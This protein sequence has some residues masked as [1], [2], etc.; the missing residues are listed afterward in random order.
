MAALNRRNI[1]A[2]IGLRVL[3]T[4][5]SIS[6]FLVSPWHV[7][8]RLWAQPCALMHLEHG[9]WSEG[10]AQPIAFDPPPIFFVTCD[11]CLQAAIAEP[12]F[13]WNAPVRAPPLPATA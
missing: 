7:H 2:L 4:I 9:A 3:L 5:F 10:L 8:N 13:F 11:F 12:A 6:L 1:I